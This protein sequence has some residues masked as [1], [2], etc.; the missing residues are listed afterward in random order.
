MTDWNKVYTDVLAVAKE[1]YKPGRRNDLAV[2]L[3]ISGHMS[4]K[5]TPRVLLDTALQGPS[6]D[7][8]SRRLVAI[9]P[10]LDKWSAAPEGYMLQAPENYEAEAAMLLGE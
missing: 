8:L 9:E 2:D 1:E 7:D 3:A 10:Y 6:S 4:G 5:E